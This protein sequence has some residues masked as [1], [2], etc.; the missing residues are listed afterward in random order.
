MHTITQV[1]A[2]YSY[3]VD[4]GD[5]SRRHVRAHKNRKFVART[6]LIDIMKEDDDFREVKFVLTDQ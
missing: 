3:V 1:R 2:S 5:G 6:H 4:L